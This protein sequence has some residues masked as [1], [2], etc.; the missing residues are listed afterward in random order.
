MLAGEGVLVVD[1]DHGEFAVGVLGEI[2]KIL[3]ITVNLMVLADN[4]PELRR[5]IDRY[6][7]P[8]NH[9]YSVKLFG[10]PAVS[11]EEFLTIGFEHLEEWRNHFLF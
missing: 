6:D 7:F 2:T 8:L 1:G 10:L 11:F 3:P 9:A 5:N 4:F